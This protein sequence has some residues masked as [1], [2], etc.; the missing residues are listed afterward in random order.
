[1]CTGGHKL[2]FH[3]AAGGAGA[4]RVDAYQE[5]GVIGMGLVVGER[6]TFEQAGYAA[7]PGR[8]VDGFEAGGERSGGRVAAECEGVLTFEKQIDGPAEACPE[9][10]L[11]GDGA[12]Y[13]FPGKAGVEDEGVGEFY[14]L[15]HEFRVAECYR[16]VW[17]SRCSWFPGGRSEIRKALVLLQG[18]GRA[19]PLLIEF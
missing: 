11:A 10:N 6:A 5:A 13:G 7:A 15:G 17:V 8:G 18:A 1:M 19:K 14:G 2:A 4:V 12:F 9:F 16:L 3:E